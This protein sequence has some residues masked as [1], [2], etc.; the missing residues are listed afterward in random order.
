MNPIYQIDAL[1]Q[2]FGARQW[3][4]FGEEDPSV[5]GAGI[6]VTRV[7]RVEPRVKAA[8]AQIMSA[9]HPLGEDDV[10]FLSFLGRFAEL[11]QGVVGVVADLAVAFVLGHVG[12]VDVGA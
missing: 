6:I 1:L 2:S 5:V 4:E 8:V 7:Q 9:R 12:E 10:P 11:A 3:L